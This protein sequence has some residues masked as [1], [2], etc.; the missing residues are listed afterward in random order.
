MQ[1]RNRLIAGAVFLV[2]AA[3]LF[4]IAQKVNLKVGEETATPAAVLEPLFPEARDEVAT[5][6]RITDNETGKTFAA[7]SEDGETW[8]I[9][10]S[11]TEPDPT[12]VVDNA[13]LRGVLVGLPSL[14]PN[15]ILSEVEALAPY[16]L[17]SVHYTITFRT[18]GNKQYTFYVGSPNPT[19]TGYY[20]RLT[21]EVG[22]ATEVYLLPSYTIEQLI[23]LLDNPPLVEPTATPAPTLT[24]TVTPEPEG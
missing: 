23:G 13:R 21:E 16:G 20:A 5:A 11:P 14:T 24:P 7:T 10:E 2:L 9:E 8:T 3:A 15:R 22:L 1:T 18:T 19:K 4:I 6:I 17:E 12:L